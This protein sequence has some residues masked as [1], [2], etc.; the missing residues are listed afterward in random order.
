M[1]VATCLE[2]SRK[3]TSSPR[4]E[5]CLS[6]TEAAAFLSSWF[7]SWEGGKIRSSLETIRKV[8]IQSGKCNYLIAFLEARNALRGG[9]SQGDVDNVRIV[10]IKV[11]AVECRFRVIG[12]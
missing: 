6:Q 7:G 12:V 4:R 9:H 10:A 5:W 8:E 2:M 11:R 3:V 1:R